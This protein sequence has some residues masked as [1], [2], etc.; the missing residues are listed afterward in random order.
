LTDRVELRLGWNAD[1][2][3]A[4]SAI[5]GS[6]SGA[7]DTLH[8]GGRVER[9]YSLAYGSKFRVTDQNRWVPRSIVIVQGFTPTGGSEG[10]STATSII[11]TYAAGWTLPN[12]WQFDT[13]MRYGFDSEEG[14]H[15]NLWA[16]SAVVRVPLGEKWAS[17]VEYFGTMTSGQE[18]N[19]T[20]HVISPGVH[21][22]PSP[23]LEVGIRLGWGLN[24]QTARFFVNAGL[25]WRF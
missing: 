3:G 18:R 23:D 16:P 8:R 25:G 14:D 9:E 21:Y 15:F 7:Q 20:K 10:T 5:S 4:G 22:L 11:T 2:G 17:H 19:T 6:G 13:A 24:D 12:R 1:I